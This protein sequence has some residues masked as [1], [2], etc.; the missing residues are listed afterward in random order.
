MRR[1]LFASKKTKKYQTIVEHTDSKQSE[2]KILLLTMMLPENTTDLRQ[3]KNIVLKIHGPRNVTSS[4]RLVLFAL[5][6]TKNYQNIVEQTDSKE[7]ESKILLLP[8]MLPRKH[9]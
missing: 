8:M 2:N 5:K 6:K 7:S 4:M 9:K 3:L 1:V